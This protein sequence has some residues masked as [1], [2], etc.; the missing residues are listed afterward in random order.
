[1]HGIRGNGAREKK[2]LMPDP[3]W[4][5]SFGFTTLDSRRGYAHGAPQEGPVGTLRPTAA[6]GSLGKPVGS[7][8]L[9]STCATTSVVICMCSVAR[10]GAL[11]QNEIK[12]RVKH[13]EKIF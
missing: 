11:S 9:L 7:L 3:L 13:D 2:A 1:M 12:R 4:R 10:A 5:S 6:L 8:W